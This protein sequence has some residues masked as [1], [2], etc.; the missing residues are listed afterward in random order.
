MKRLALMGL[1]MSLAGL[2]CSKKEEAT[3]APTAAPAP[4]AAATTA[5]DESPATDDSEDIPTEQDFEDEAEQQITAS[6]LET[7]LDALE[8]EI[9]E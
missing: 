7:E 8:K 9:G 2:G 1:A 6:N 4:S 3:P 5:T